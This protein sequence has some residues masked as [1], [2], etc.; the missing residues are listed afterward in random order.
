MRALLRSIVFVAFI[1]SCFAS[2]RLTLQ[3]GEDC[4][5]CVGL[6]DLTN[7]QIPLTVKGINIINSNISKI[8]TD[9]F[10]Q[11][12]QSLIEL[13]ITGCGIEEI[14]PDAFRGLTKLRLLGLVNNKIRKIDASWIRGLSNLKSLILWQ[15]RIVD[16]DPKIYDLLPELQVWDLAYNNL[17]KCL[18]PELLKKLKN[19]ETILIAGNSW[20]YR[21]RASM[22]WYLG[23]H[24]I[25]FIKDWSIWSDLL[26]EEC[27]AH[28]T[29]PNDV[30]S[31]N[32]QVRILTNKVSHLEAEIDIL[33]KTKM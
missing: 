20:S 12:S 17:T 28:D 2:C 33:K 24:H 8:K 9:A 31:L 13:N 30:G 29:L 23:S 6:K 3:D 16:V 1:A 10:S 21:C 14:E 26:I 4:Y 11:Y 18:S 19:L 5:E 25:R 27:L 32:E 22:A 7:L 15:N